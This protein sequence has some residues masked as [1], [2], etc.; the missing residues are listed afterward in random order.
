MSVSSTRASASS[1]VS[2]WLATTTEARRS[3]LSWASSP[4]GVFSEGVDTAKPAGARCGGRATE[5]ELVELSRRRVLGERRHREA[6]G[7]AEGGE[8]LDDR[9]VADEHELGLGQIRLHLDL[10]TAT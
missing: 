10:P 4:A 5:S 8:T 9:S 7:G 3:R 1:S 6:G 2:A